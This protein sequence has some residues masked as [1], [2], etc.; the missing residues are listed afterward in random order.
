MVDNV[1]VLELDARAPAYRHG[2]G[3]NPGDLRT[4][5][6][7]DGADGQQHGFSAETGDDDWGS[8]MEPQPGRARPTINKS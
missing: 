3:P 8:S 6:T 7:D 4:A 5:S 2:N 1:A